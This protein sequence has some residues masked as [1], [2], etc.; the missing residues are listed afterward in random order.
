MARTHT[1]G[2]QKAAEGKSKSRCM[3]G[4]RILP[5]QASLPRADWPVV[6]HVFLKKV[7]KIL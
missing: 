6:V 3:N 2:R 7:I 5:E 1:M 4:K